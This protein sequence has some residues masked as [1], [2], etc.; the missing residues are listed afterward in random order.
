MLSS[1]RR[2]FVNGLALAASMAHFVAPMRA[3]ASVALSES[4]GP[5]MATML[6]N[7]RYFEVGSIQARARYA[8]WVTT[9]LGYTQDENRKFPVLYVTDGNGAAPA[10]IPRLPY[11]PIDPI[12]PIQPFIMVCIGYPD[13]GLPELAVRARDLLPPEEPAPVNLDAAMD[14]VVEQGVLDRAGADL[15]ARNLR[16]P[17]G[18]K[19]LQFIT[20][21]LHPLILQGWRVD[22]ANGAG[23]FGHSYGGL[24]ATYAAMM[25]TPLIRTVCASSPGITP[26]V[27]AVLSMYRAHAERRTDFSGRSLHIAVAEKE[28]TAATYYQPLVGAGTTELM[29]LAGTSPLAGLKITTDIIPDESHFSVL[30]PAFFGFLREYYGRASS[31]L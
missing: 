31:L 4:A 7:T 11:L 8:I 28:I 21:E 10:L 29:I 2:Q 23:L 19:F 25:R 16:H 20:Q 24:F 30:V 1:N 14:A 22:E 12:N 15:Y 6:P 27:S 9:P 3:A 5:P 26:K 17:A 13:D 18:D